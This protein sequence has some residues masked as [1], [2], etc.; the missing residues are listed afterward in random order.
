VNTCNGSCVL[1]D[2][3]KEAETN[4]E[5]SK[6]PANS[7]TRIS[8]DYFA[9]ENNYSISISQIVKKRGSVYDEL[10]IH[11]TT[12]GAIFHPPQF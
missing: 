3:L 6:Y 12:L 11:Q 9:F 1:T 7:K 4:Q 5:N 8:L 10:A 2:Q